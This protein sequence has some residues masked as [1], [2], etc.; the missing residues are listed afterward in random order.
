MRLTADQADAVTR[1]GQDVCV[2]AGPGSGKTVLLAER[3][4]RRVE[5]GV[6]PLRLLA[7]TF[8]RQA[9]NEL[10]RRLA[11]E[12]SGS[13][14]F[15]DE[16]ERAQICTVGDFCAGLLRQYAIQAGLDP[17]FTI[18]EP[19]EARSA[20][21]EA[22]ESALDSLLQADP[23]GVRSLLAALDTADFF[24]DLADAHES[25][26]VTATNAREGAAARFSAGSDAFADLLAAA[27]AI[28]EARLPDG[29]END[30]LSVWAVRDWARRLLALASAP[31][32]PGHFQLLNEFDFSPGAVPRSSA[33]HEH[34]LAVKATLLRAAR[35]S[36]IAAFYSRQ[37]ALLWQALEAVEESYRARKRALNSLDPTD[38]EECA[39][40]LLRDDVAVRTRVRS[41]FD[42]VLMDEPQDATPLQATLVSLV[43]RRD[44]F[45]AVGDANASIFGRRFAEPD[46]FRRLRRT[47]E[48]SGKRVDRLRRNFRSRAEILCAVDAVLHGCD[49]IEAEDLE[50]ARVF[51]TGEA[52]PCVEVIAAAGPDAHAAA[53]LEAQA[54]AC[55]VRE[56]EGGLALEDRDTGEI[57]RARLSDM[58]ILV[59]D[60]GALAAF[61]RE[62]DRRGIRHVTAA[63]PAHSREI[64]D[65]L[66]LLRVLVNPRDEISMAAVLRSPFAGVSSEGLLRLK[67]A[68]N[69]GAG[70]LDPEQ[71]ELAAFT[72]ADRERLIL[73][74]GL[75]RD[76]RM[77]A[78]EIPPDRLLG[79]IIGATG[80]GRALPAA[81]RT[82]IADLLRRIRRRSAARPRHPA[83]LV[84]EVEAMRAHAQDS[85]TPPA[86][87]NAVRLLTI[88]AAKGLEFPIVFLAALQH[89]A[90]AAPPSLSFSPSAGLVAR[91]LDPASG[92][93]VQD[94]AYTAFA[95]ELRHRQASEDSRLLYVGMTRAEEKLVLSFAH[96]GT[97]QNWA[98]RVGGSLGIDV[99]RKCRLET[100]AGRPG[101]EF[102]IGAWILAESSEPGDP[103][104][105]P[106][107]S[108]L[109][110]LQAA[111][112]NGAAGSG[113]QD[114]AAAVTSIALFHGCPR[115]YFLGRYLGFRAEPAPPR[116]LGHE[117]DDESPDASE[118]DRTVR[119][120]LTE[121]TVA[122]ASQQERDLAGRF[123]NSELGR[124]AASAAR[125]ERDFEFLIAVGEVIV[126]GRIDIWFEDHGELVLAG[127]RTESAD[128]M[129]DRA[130]EYEMQVRLYA[131][132]LERYTGRLP[133]RAFL[134]FLR[135]DLIVPVSLGPAEMHGAFEAV[136]AFSSAQNSM[137]FPEREGGQCSRCEFCG[138]MC[139]ARP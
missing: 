134:H 123:T 132:A 97:P 90:P 4:R 17:S 13:L 37:R 75:I 126:Q 29:E 49:G 30:R 73:L 6:S 94:L 21:R 69:L 99:A 80:Y 9:A 79:R 64:T 15:R 76:A 51:R 122:H 38:V 33:V 24:G 10:R 62:L 129:R 103:P 110:V 14:G 20:L 115:R 36:L 47:L 57:R 135:P 55:R 130:G 12:F 113:Q 65:V 127:F 43:R 133:H 1:S 116:P 136:R 109:A 137:D 100:C 104:L 63:R 16:I 54:V 60:A 138:R 128:D 23:G 68:G 77:L 71:L 74:G 124:R 93:P 112:L 121:R 56:L 111:G 26:R 117:I 22:A 2:S 11:L 72:P 82:S 46:S 35:Q 91:W 39:V 89:H 108:S 114:S 92:A 5:Q 45:F 28:A 50:A 125:V 119:G 59:R 31:L 85:A 102:K 7:I 86:A 18:L 41:G 3:F 78:D 101:R 32:S 118:L 61:E 8:T 98:A 19:H 58:A 66:H 48:L 53:A 34:V 120:L 84:D 87:A 27:R 70:V 42:E 67:E 25:M 139:P 105:Q 81:G 88:R 95:D 52:E 106:S 107:R 96:S 131:L 44:R 83:D 40:R